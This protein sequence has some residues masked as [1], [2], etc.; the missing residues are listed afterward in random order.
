MISIDTALKLLKT[1]D[2][3]NTMIAVGKES[4]DSIAELIRSLHSRLAGVEP[5]E[6]TREELVDMLIRLNPN[7]EMLLKHLNIPHTI[8]STCVDLFVSGSAA[9]PADVTRFRYIAQ[10]MSETGKLPLKTGS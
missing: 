1:K 8:T 2:D 5:C 3:P 4:A 7:N 6:V 9:A 10:V